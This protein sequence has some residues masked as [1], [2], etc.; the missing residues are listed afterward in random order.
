MA[1]TV[2]GSIS[3]GSADTHTITSGT[4]NTSTSTA[5]IAAVI[6]YI[7]GGGN[8][9]GIFSDSKSNT[10]APRTA[11][12]T[13]D[14]ALRFFDAV[15]SP[16]VGSGHTFTVTGTAIYASEA[17]LAIAGSGAFDQQNGATATNVSVLSTGSVTPGEDNEIVIAVIATRNNAGTFSIDNGF[18]IAQQLDNDGNRFAIGMAYKIQTT[19]T[20]VN[21]QWSWPGGAQDAVA[22][23]ATI[24]AAAAGDTRA[25]GRI[26]IRQA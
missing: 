15:S 7:P 13:S 4:L 14:I 22:V 18:T 1:I 17:V 10:W 11:Q 25:D 24:K 21:P 5:L 23:I 6:G 19:A 9:T 8:G 16:T 2:V 20:A 3:A 26:V 12:S